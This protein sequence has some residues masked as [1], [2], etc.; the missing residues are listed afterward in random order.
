VNGVLIGLGPV[1]DTDGVSGF[2]ILRIGLQNFHLPLPGLRKFLEVVIKGGNLLEAGDVVGM[3]LKNL[4]KAV[5]GH[6][7][8][9]L[10]FRSIQAGDNL[11]RISGSEIKPGHGIS[12]IEVH[13]TLK[14]IDGLFILRLFVGLHTF[15]ELIAGLEAFAAGCGGHDKDRS[16]SQHR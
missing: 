10:I 3:L 1:N 2:R 4:E 13:G 5:D 6:L 14:V 12:G 16:G 9:F 7:G 11:L 8:G 15:V